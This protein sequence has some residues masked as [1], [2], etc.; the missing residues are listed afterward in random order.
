MKFFLAVLIWMLL[1]I[2]FVVMAIDYFLY[3]REPGNFHV[4]SFIAVSFVY[5]AGKLEGFVGL[6]RL[7]DD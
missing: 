2:F 3:S 4:L 6:D 5:I 1:S 7:F